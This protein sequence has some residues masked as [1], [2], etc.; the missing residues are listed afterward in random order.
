[1]L[2]V[3]AAPGEAFD[4]VR[5]SPYRAAN[6]VVPLLLASVAGVV[7]IL[8]AFAQPAVV[9]EIIEQQVAQFDRAVETGKMTDAQ[10]DAARG[11]MEQMR[12]M[13]ATFGRVFG[14]LG[15][16]LV[17]V[18]GT[19]FSAFI[20]WL[21]ARMGLKS[22]VAYW[23]CMEVA[24]LS[25]LVNLVGTILTLF[26]VVYRGSISANLSVA[27]LIPNLPPGK[28]LF[29]L[30]SGLNP[31]FLW[32]TGLLALGLSRLA[33][34]PFGVTAGWLFGLYLMFT[35]LFAGLAMLRP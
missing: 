12:P 15:V 31:I 35:L 2:N 8:V 27:M 34:R 5:A 11:Q 3:L 25:S 33:G 7:F 4:E 28:P 20:L 9:D 1:M 22:P 32:W 26:L 10:A 23:K 16:I 19:F 14:A 18:A 24:G 29:T 30:L 17:T 13:I 6:W 21:V